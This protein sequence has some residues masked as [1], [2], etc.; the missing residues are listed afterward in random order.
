MTRKKHKRSEPDRS[1]PLTLA[2]LAAHD[3][4]CSD[5]LIDNAYYRA[6]IR[7]NRPKYNPLRGI[8]EDE[9]PQVLLHKVIVAKDIPAAEKALLQVSGIKRYRNGLKGKAVQENFLR[10]L[11][12]YIDMYRTDCPWEVST[13]NRYTITTFEA[14]VTSRSRIKQH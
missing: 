13:T 10:H 12:K 8:K 5:A 9:I 14:A 3:D 1:H 11:R 6:Q 4:A 7:K 2:E